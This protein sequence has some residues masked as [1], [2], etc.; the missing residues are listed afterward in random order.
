MGHLKR[1]IHSDMSQ[2]SASANL[3]TPQRS[4]REA[5]RGRSC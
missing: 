2:H 5:A 1:E 4:E 3:G